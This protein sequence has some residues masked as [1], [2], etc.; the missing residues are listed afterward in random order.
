MKVFN[1]II[2]VFAIFGSL[3]CIFW[4]EESFLNAGWVVA[5][6]LLMWGICS[7]VS[8]IFFKRDQKEGKEGKE[9]AGT[10]TV[11]LLLGIGA[12]VVSLLAL[13][14]PAVEALFYIIILLVFVFWLL[15]Y[16]VYSIVKAIKSSKNSD[17]NGWIFSL[18][19]G[20]IMVLIGLFCISDLLFEVALIGVIIG[21]GLMVAGVRLISS[22]FEP[23]FE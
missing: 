16:G 6:L 23:S 18:I 5:I 20:I 15:F 9:L 21:I 10:G 11:G 14:V 12:A 13:F 17:S 4:P 1:A 8:A 2:G 3:Y 7:I 19:L 22:A